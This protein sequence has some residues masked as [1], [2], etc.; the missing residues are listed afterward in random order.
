MTYLSLPWLITYEMYKNVVLFIR[1]LQFVIITRRA[2]NESEV[3]KKKYGKKFRE[4]SWWH[5]SIA[6]Y[7]CQNSFPTLC[8]LL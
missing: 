1:K 5:V 7:H 3:N 6:K 2:I 4:T 8:T